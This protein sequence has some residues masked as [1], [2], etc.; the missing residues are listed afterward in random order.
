[1]LSFKHRSG[2]YFEQAI[3]PHQL[4]QRATCALQIPSLDI[5]ADNIKQRE[6]FL[7]AL[8]VD[9][10][11]RWRVSAG[12]SATV[13]TNSAASSEEEATSAAHM[14]AFYA[15][16]EHLDERNRSE[17][18][19]GSS[20]AGCN[21]S[22][23][24]NSIASPIACPDDTELVE[25]KNKCCGEKRLHDWSV[26]ATEKQY[27]SIKSRPH[28]LVHYVHPCNYGAQLV[29]IDD[30]PSA[31]QEKARANGGNGASTIGAAGGRAPSRDARN[32]LMNEMLSKVSD[33]R[34]R[35]DGESL[36]N[37]VEEQRSLRAEAADA[38]RRRESRIKAHL[39]QRDALACNKMI[40][41]ARSMTPDYS[42]GENEEEDD[43]Y[44]NDSAD[45]Q[46]ELDGEAELSNSEEDAEEDASQ[47]SDNQSDT[48]G[49]DESD[50]FSDENNDDDDEE[51][52]ETAN[53]EPAAESAET[54]V[55]A[56]ADT[57]STTN[58]AEATTVPPKRKACRQT[59]V[60][61]MVGVCEPSDSLAFFDELELPYIVQWGAEV[62]GEK[63]RRKLHLFRKTSRQVRGWVYNSTRSAYHWLGTI[64][65]LI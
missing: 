31:S 42:E 47:E 43:T 50:T 60:E 22:T 12:E 46:S 44:S 48:D 52:E 59:T 65:A 5:P 20:S 54:V 62:D 23:I 57:A 14:A 16:I 28:V 51:K 39:A 29:S 9:Y 1:M 6:R 40:Q 13:A 61:M 21:S 32:A 10:L 24:A 56:N 2:V 25:C 63:Q 49:D 38:Q 34:K 53:D 64:E 17:L 37:Q 45:E 55:A 8:A 30:A 27:F 41:R 3:E 4:N 33:M 15:A 7:I 11:C 36:S 18:V 26:D 19:A 35:T 58:A